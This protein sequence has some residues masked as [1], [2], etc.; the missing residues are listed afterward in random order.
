VAQQHAAATVAL[1]SQLV[2]DFS[3]VLTARGLL[4]EGF[5]ESGYGKTA[6]EAPDWDYHRGT[7]NVKLKAFS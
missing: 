1:Y 7:W 3:G 6:T 4:F 5:I 2:H